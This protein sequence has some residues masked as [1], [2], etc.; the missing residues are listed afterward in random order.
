MIQG[1]NSFQQ[2]DFLNSKEVAR[3]LGVNVS[4]VKRW[5]QSGRL[6]CQTT[7]GGHRR[8]TMADLVNLVRENESE[9]KKSNIF[10]LDSETDVQVSYRIIKRDYDFLKDYMLEKALQSRSEIITKIISGLYMVRTPLYE[11]YD[12]LLTPV[13]R[14]LGD[15]WVAGELGIVEE[16]FA[17]QAIRD[18][19]V[20]LQG[21]IEIRGEKVGRA[22]L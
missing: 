18:S 20:R 10:S 3:I 11:I 12:T 13:L 4:T 5:T 14:H 8:F 21:I 1:S 15:K 19:I 17:S 7:V 9:V 6:P 2:L 16:H 22:L